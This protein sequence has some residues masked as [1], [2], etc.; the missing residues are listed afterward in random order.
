MNVTDRKVQKP[1][2]DR[3]IYMAGCIYGDNSVID[4]LHTTG[5]RE[6]VNTEF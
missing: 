2:E 4:G 1:A 5:Q 6:L 3:T